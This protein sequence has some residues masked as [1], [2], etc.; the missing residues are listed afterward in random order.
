MQIYDAVLL[1][2]VIEGAYIVILTRN[3]LKT[4]R[5]DYDL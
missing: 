3:Y 5:G 4:R 1:S 2:T